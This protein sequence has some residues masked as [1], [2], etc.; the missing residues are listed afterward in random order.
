MPKPREQANSAP[1][2]DDLLADRR[3]P[4]MMEDPRNWVTT[5]SY[6]GMR[7]DYVG[8]WSWDAEQRTNDFE[9]FVPVRYSDLQVE[10]HKDR[11]DVAN[12]IINHVPRL[13][14]LHNILQLAAKSSMERPGNSEK[15]PE[16]R[17]EMP[18]DHTR[19]LHT[20][21]V[22]GIGLA[23]LKQNGADTDEH[24][25]RLYTVGSLLHDIATPAFGDASKPIDRDGLDEEAHWYK[26][27]GAKGWEYI[28]SLGLTKDE[29]D[30]V[31]HN[32]G[33][34][35]QLLDIA[36]RIAY[37][38][39]DAFQMVG[40]PE[41]NKDE[42]ARSSIEKC[43]VAAPDIG[44]IYKN[45]RIKDRQV[46]CDSPSNLR[47]F[48]RLRGQLFY[49]GYF[50]PPNNCR[51][52]TLRELV[53]PLYPS[54]LN[55]DDLRN[56]NDGTLLKVLDDVYKPKLKWPTLFFDLGYWTPAFNEVNNEQERDAS[57]KQLRRR[58]MYVIG[59]TEKYGFSPGTKVLVE[60]DGRIQRA[61]DAFPGLDAELRALSD[62]RKSKIQVFYIDPSNPEASVQRLLSLIRAAHTYE[63]KKH[64]K[65]TDATGRKGRVYDGP[66]S[67][68]LESYRAQLAA[69]PDL[70]L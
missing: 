47:K 22:M 50:Y 17:V 46:Y 15:L 24:L 57:V 11:D 23:I 63:K 9:I 25:M 8:P 60:Y 1:S 67:P 41:R 48:L 13:N 12:G 7:S 56:L 4:E 18:H 61:S 49:D 33:V 16:K 32:K 51:D 5:V 43:V 59:S 30:D 21:Q 44:N 36:D 2:F 64:A 20:L 42:S 52:V 53:A 10:V 65:S 19:Y 14:R 40:T 55:A 70:I 45:I 28:E 27:V 69:S 38:T 31:I 62:K 54:V 6:L 68:V 34:A 66:V 3:T 29:I 35:G 37:V 26:M 39:Q 58:G